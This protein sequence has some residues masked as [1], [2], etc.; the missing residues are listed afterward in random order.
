MDKNCGVTKTIKII[1]SK[2]TILI[3]H[4][5]CEEKKRFGELQR[6]LAGISPKTLSLRLQQLE[7]NGIV[8]K[9]VFAEVPLHVEYSLTKKGASLKLI[10]D[11]MQQWGEKT[12]N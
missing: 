8:H 6:S 3:L 1:G 4:E 7:K 12:A 10:I 9:K 5:L 11:V 2:W